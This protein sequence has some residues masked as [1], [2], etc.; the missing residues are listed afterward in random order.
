MST[1]YKETRKKEMM[2]RIHMQYLQWIL[3]WKTDFTD[4]L[5]S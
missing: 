1:K 2:G 3:G 5:D 4:Y